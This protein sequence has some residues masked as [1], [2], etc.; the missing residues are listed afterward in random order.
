[1]SEL[2]TAMT[3]SLIWRK[4]LVDGRKM[5]TSRE[6]QDLANE[7][8][9]N[10]KRS[11]YYLQEEGYIVRILRGIFYIRG[12]EERDRGTQDR[13][14]YELV[15]MALKVKGVRNWYLA[16][17]TALKLNLMTHEYFT[18]DHVITDSFRTTKAITI[19]GYRFRFIRRSA[20]YFS[21]G[22]LRKD[23]IFVSDRERTVLD[24][25][26]RDFLGS[27]EPGRITGWIREYRDAVDLERL[28]GYLAIYPPAFGRMV[29]DVS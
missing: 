13:S 9:R 25:A 14:M 7:L 10:P 27:R 4:L 29:E 28:A 26:Y 5:A 20:V 6:I 21:S 1:M 11:L 8:G 24:L 12:M 17:E 18:T 19:T 23:N 15:G 2:V 16:H 3:A 22:I